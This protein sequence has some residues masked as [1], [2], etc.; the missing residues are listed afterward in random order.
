MNIGFYLLD[1]TMS[2][3]HKNILNSISGL[4]KLRPYDNIVLFN[5]KFN[6][7]DTDARYYTLHINQA[8]FF[9]GILFVFGTKEALLTQTFPCPTKQVIYM[10]QPEWSSHTNIPYIFWS[11]IYLQSNTEL[12]TDQQNTHDLLNICWKKPLPL[13]DSLTTENIDHV[14]Q[15]LQ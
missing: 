10:S 2:P 7:I 15:A 6:A 1:I 5:N 11:N 8:K 9:N 12:L 4:S 3:E 13:I 14:I